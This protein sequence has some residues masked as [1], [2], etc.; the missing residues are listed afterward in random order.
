ML[1][2]IIFDLDGVLVETKDLHFKAL[3]MALTDFGATPIT[4]KDHIAR[5]DGKSTKTK[6]S[7]L[8][9]DDKIEE[10]NARKQEYT[11]RLLQEEI[12]PNIELLRT[13]RNL[14]KSGYKLHVASNSVR[15]T[16][17]TVLDKL[18]L[19]RM[20]TFTV[21]NED[22]KN[23]KPNPEM[24]LK[25]MLHEGVGPKET[26]IVE[27]S[28]VGRQG[29]YSS[30]AHVCE[31]LSPADVKPV[32][33]HSAILRATGDRMM[34]R[35]PNL[36]ILIPMAGAGSRFEKAGYTFPKPL[37][38]VAGKPMIQVV[39]DNLAMQGNFIFIVRKEHYDQYNLEY[40]LNAM[41]PDCKII[42][43]DHLTEGAACT[44]LLAK[45]Y[46]DN[47]QQL[48]LANSDQYVEWDSSDFMYS[49][50]GDHID[51]G[52][53]V[54]ENT[55]PKWSYAKTDKDGFVTEVAEK[56]PISNKATVGIYHWKRG[57]DYVKYAEQMIKKN[58]RVNNEFYVCPVFNEAIADGCKIKT[59]HTDYMHGLGTPEDLSAFLKR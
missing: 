32:R 41:A 9:L 57:S 11:G 16:V 38:D 2:L 52:I 24:Y 40:V 4:Y 5:F 46:I 6:L 21:S 27:D 13:I 26:L 36:N 29:A 8:G 37:I 39:K 56:K 31:V 30:G 35:D 19:D 12:K 45:E 14:W 1:K 10:I 53:L 48:I 25:C 18:M 49:L 15:Q 22:V 17:D 7:M 58:I 43:V 33:I 54:F 59:Y 3:N 28:Y 44:T 55:H 50:Q 34:W 47:D 23:S 20:I 42:Q 51:G